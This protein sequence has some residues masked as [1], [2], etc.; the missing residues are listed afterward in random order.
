MRARAT[1]QSPVE[2]LIALENGKLVVF[3]KVTDVFRETTGG[4]NKGKLTIDGLDDH[5]GKTITID[6]QNE[7]LSCREVD[8]EGGKHLRACV[9]DL[10]TILDADTAQPIPTEEVRFGIR[11]AVVVMRVHPSMSTEQALK[12]VGPEAFGLPKDVQYEPLCDFVD[13][14][15]VGPK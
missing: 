14:G 6:F 2:A 3:G 9:P 8:G 4:F 13:R 1:K 11:V 10:I 15:P 12:F 5:S 7:F